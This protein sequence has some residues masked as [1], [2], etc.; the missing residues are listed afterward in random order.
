MASTAPTQTVPIAHA[1]PITD[2]LLDRIIR[3]GAQL[4]A[5]QQPSDSDLTLILLCASPLAT[6]LLQRRRAMGVIADM[7]D[8]DNVTFLPCT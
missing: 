8:L 5:N 2:F 3:A 4:Q 7:T 6:E 1:G